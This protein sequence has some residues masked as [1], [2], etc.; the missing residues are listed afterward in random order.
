M[1]FCVKF[2]IVKFNFERLSRDASSTL[3]DTDIWLCR[4]VCIC[5][6]SY[7]CVFVCMSKSMHARAYMCVSASIYVFMSA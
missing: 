7:S 5:V 1:K 2:T 3:S 4:C 6:C